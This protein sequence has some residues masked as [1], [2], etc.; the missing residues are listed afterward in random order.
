MGED[1]E[2]SV[3]R[4]IVGGF[5]KWASSGGPALKLGRGE[6]RNSSILS[7]SGTGSMLTEVRAGLGMPGLSPGRRI[8]YRF[9]DGGVVRGGKCCLRTKIDNDRKRACL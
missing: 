9:D 4:R 3:E 1:G 6:R 8:A 7:V 2:G 5:L